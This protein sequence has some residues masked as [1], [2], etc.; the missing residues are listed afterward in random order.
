MT[1]AEIERSAG[2]GLMRAR[3][4]T[5]A[6]GV[7]RPPGKARFSFGRPVRYLLYGPVTGTL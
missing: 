3:H 1:L 7:S 5:P 4:A 2:G 6:F